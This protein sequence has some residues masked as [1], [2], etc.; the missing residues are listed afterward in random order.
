MSNVVSY[1]IKES[2]G[3][4]SVN[5]PPVNALSHE[6][7]VGIIEALNQAQ[8]DDSKA[9][10]L[11]CEGRTFIAG[12]DI[13]E[14]GQPRKNPILPEMLD[15]FDKSK[16][17]LVA[18][19]HGTALGGGFETALSC[20]YRCALD[21][22]KFGLPEIN[23]GLLPGAGGT[24][25]VPRLAGAEAALEIM[26]S[27]RP[28]AASKALSLNLID[29]IIEGDDLL[30]SA[31]T[32]TQSLLADNAPLR[33]VRDLQV[34]AV[35]EGFF[36]VAEKEITKRSKGLMAPQK[37]LNCVKAACE[38]DFDAGMAIELESF[39]TCL[40]SP[41]SAG[42]RHAFFAERQTSKIA[43]LAKDT[44]LR[45]INKVGIIGAG[46]MGGGIAMNFANVGIPVTLLEL[47]EEA[48]EKGTNTIRK[49]YA[50]SVKKGRMSEA[51][52]EARM[53]L[54]STSTSYESLG[55]VDLVIE[56]VFENP[57]VK[58]EVFK[59]LD[60]VCKQGAILASNTSYQN[61]DDIAS[62]TS[63]PQDVIGMHFFSPA[64][65]MKLLEVVRGEKTADDVLATAMKLAKSIRKVPVLSRVCYGFI[66]NRMFGPYIRTA[67]M[68]L[69][70]GA[71][72]EQIDNAAT[73]WGMAMGPVSVIDL[74]GIDIGVS[75]RRAKADP[76]E[77]P[78]N[79]LASDLM[80]DQGRL[81][82]KTGAGF[83]NYD[84]ETRARTTDDD[85]LALIEAAAEERGIEQRSFTDKEIVERLVYA[86]V[87]EGASILEEGIAQ[88]ASD[89]DITYLY[90]Y[91]FPA[92]R[93]GPMF[94][95][96][97]IGLDKIVERMADFAISIQAEHWEPSPLLKSLASEGKSFASFSSTD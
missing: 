40:E 19:V 17:L 95:A 69:L 82:Q 72:P 76:N 53:N 96:D 34:P 79:F 71:T 32:Y 68:L 46:L 27:G 14:F 47:S 94:Y 73:S 42:M 57:D 16:K 43:G 81:G 70:E 63:R 21:S 48:L 75:A 92:H 33:R 4:I 10:V 62:V 26:T 9:I 64:N 30:A 89:I 60:E 90:G 44:P 55:D 29:H 78:L 31:I 25:R 80:F 67:N 28:I 77:N 41:E 97:Q 39:M 3:V 20:H 66:G 5:N 85:M 24:Q 83:Y 86:L 36:A 52:L 50:R 88:R 22:A 61:I 7:R 37:I 84:P 91:G 87:N 58:K 23:L 74:A 13:K 6:L 51:D 11:F 18:A 1:E 45:P 65:V 38:V 12:A 15:E 56:A 93:G 59:K 35:P 49:N 8:D 54:I 2:I